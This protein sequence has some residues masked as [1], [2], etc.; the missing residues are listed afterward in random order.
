MENEIEENKMKSN[1][2]DNKSDGSFSLT[3][4]E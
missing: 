3:L 2:N 4:E 1:Y